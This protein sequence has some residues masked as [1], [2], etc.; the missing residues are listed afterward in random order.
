MTK[1]L[2][3]AN[4]T[5]LSLFIAG[6]SGYAQTAPPPPPPAPVAPVAPAAPAKPVVKKKKPQPDIKVLKHDHYTSYFSTSQHIPVLVTYTLTKEMV[7]CSNPF[8]KMDKYAPDPMAV[9]ITSLAGDYLRSGYDRGHNM[10]AGNNQC[11]EDAM[12]ESFYFSNMTPQAHFF[13]SGVWA[14]LEK[15][16]RKEAM[17]HGEIRV[18]TGSV[19]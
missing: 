4:I 17:L 10:S 19:W 7:W 18:A 15:Q 3:I 2:K 5:L 13:N 8:R 1:M 11:D 16:E 9:S 14:E 6:Y 12:T